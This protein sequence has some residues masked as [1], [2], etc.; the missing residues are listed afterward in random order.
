MAN[1]Y[2]N[3]PLPA[4]NGAGAAVD[5]SAMGA[6]K[7]VVVAGSFQG[8]IIE[9][10]ASVDGGT[11]FA[12]ILCFQS[13]EREVVV[14]LV[15][16][17]MRVLVSGRKSTIPFTATIDVG[18]EPAA[19]LFMA[20]PMP[21]GNGPGAA[22]DL[23]S[24]G[25]FATFIAG[26]SF[27]GAVIEVQ[28]SEDGLNFAPLIQFAS[29][30]GSWSQLITAKKVRANVS[31]RRNTVPFTGSL[32]VGAVEAG[33]SGG[34]GARQTFRYV[35]TGLEDPNGFDINL[36]AARLTTNYNAQVTGGG[37]TDQLTF[38]VPIALQT[39]TKITVRSS[40]VLTAGDVLLI[41][42]E[43]LT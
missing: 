33:G 7:S 30:G 15:A 37:L 18:A 43:D 29:Y 34:G 22:V 16:D 13:G 42:A 19:P 27:Q 28:I 32:A 4:L 3:L 20:L 10:Q 5:T 2:V 39:T 11:V 1:V 14:D 23:S 25:V 40:A 12:P 24:F 26:G 17:H 8:A 36:P 6:T 9:V 21:V 31:G 41:T 35:A 38:D